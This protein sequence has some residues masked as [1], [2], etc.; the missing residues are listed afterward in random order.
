MITLKSA[1]G[2]HARP[3]SLVVAEAKKYTCDCHL[4]KEGSLFNAKSIMDLMRMEAKNGDEIDVLCEGD[5][6]EIARK[7]ILLCLETL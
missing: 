5:D 3:A 7:N 4:I 6:A 2:L 1:Q